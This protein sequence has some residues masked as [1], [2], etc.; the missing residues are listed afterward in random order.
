M[1]DNPV[2]SLNEAQLQKIVA[3]IGTQQPQWL[4]VVSVF[5]S[6]LLAMIVGILLDRFRAWRDRIKATREKQEHEIQKINAVISGLTFDIEYLLHIA[7]QNILPHYRDASAIYQQMM[8]DPESDDHIREVIQSQHKYPAVFKTCPDMYLIEYDFAQELPF[9]IERDPELVKHSGWLVGGVRE[10]KDI[11]A[12]R[13]RNIEDSFSLTG[14][15]DNAHNLYS[16]RIVIRTQASMASTE[17]IVAAQLFDVLIRLANGLVKI[18]Q[19]YKISAKKSRFTLP[20][21]LAE[22]MKELKD[23]SAKTPIDS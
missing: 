17:C 10:I 5:V 18:S 20:D 11:T 22:T 7:S 21:S 15:R 13:N 19:G 8:V 23:I 9:A 2:L 3:A 12:R 16:F 6:A 4:P 1:A 14:L